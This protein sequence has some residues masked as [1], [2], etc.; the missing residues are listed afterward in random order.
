MLSI[1]RRFSLLLGS[2]DRGTLGTSIRKT[3]SLMSASVPSLLVKACSL[4][5]L[6]SHSAASF[7]ASCKIIPPFLNLFIS[8]TLAPSGGGGEML[9][10]AAST[11]SLSSVILL[12]SISSVLSSRR[13]CLL[14]LSR[15]LVNLGSSLGRVGVWLLLCMAV[16]LLE[17]RASLYDDTVLDSWPVVAI[18]SFTLLPI[19]CVSFW[20]ISVAP[21]RDEDVFCMSFWL[22]RALS[23]R[24]LIL[25]KLLSITPSIF[26]PSL[27][28]KVSM[29]QLYECSTPAPSCTSVANACKTRRRLGGVSLLNHL[30]ILSI[31]L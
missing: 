2:K 25:L 11:F 9:E 5:E 21:A 15:S 16:L 22:A 28:V 6:R 29:S 12:P 1:S 19:S 13:I 20:S 18:T 8:C 4:M 30:R 31:I 23:T 24:V 17:R 26:N 10:S 7:D 14:F 3:L 27:W